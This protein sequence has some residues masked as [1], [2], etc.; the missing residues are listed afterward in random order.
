MNFLSGGTSYGGGN[1]GANSTTNIS[2][3][4][5]LLKKNCAYSKK[6]KNSIARNNCK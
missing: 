4:P 3:V 5:L 6:L 2:L 1:F